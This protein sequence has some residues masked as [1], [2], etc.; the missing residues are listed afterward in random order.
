[1]SKCIFTNKVVEDLTEIWE[2]TIETWSEQQAEKN[3]IT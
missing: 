1:M 2:Y 3:I